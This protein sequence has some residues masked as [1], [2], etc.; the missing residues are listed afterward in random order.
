MLASKAQSRAELSQVQA[1][2]TTAM[3]PTCTVVHRGVPPHSCSPVPAAAPPW[4][5]SRGSKCV[6]RSPPPRHQPPAGRAGA[7]AWWT[8]GRR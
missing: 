6:R 4:A 5:G 2:A 1:A 8:G 7:A 3:A